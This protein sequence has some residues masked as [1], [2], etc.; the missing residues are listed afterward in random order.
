[1]SKSAEKYITDIINL[2]CPKMIRL[3]K[4]TDYYYPLLL[5][6]ESYPVFL[7]ARDHGGRSNLLCL[8]PN[9]RIRIIKR[10]ATL[11]KKPKKKK[12]ARKNIKR[13]TRLSTIIRNMKTSMIPMTWL[14]KNTRSKKT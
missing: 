7:E 1:M 10:R 11:E 2:H 6:L 9:K 5:L 12:L 14:T 3:Q 8:R 4:Y 13:R